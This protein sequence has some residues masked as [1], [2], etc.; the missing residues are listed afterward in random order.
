ME[1]SLNDGER[2]NYPLYES[3]VRTMYEA[4]RCIGLHDEGYMKYS[5]CSREAMYTQTIHC[6]KAW[7]GVL[8]ERF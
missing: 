1:S 6:V 4:K 8:M 5:R 3:M 2:W 7:Q